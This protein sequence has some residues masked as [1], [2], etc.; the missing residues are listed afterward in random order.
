MALRPLFL[1]KAFIA[2]HTFKQKL[3]HTIA[4]ALQADWAQRRITD[5]TERPFV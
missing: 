2:S 4:P 3:D 1:D 5:R